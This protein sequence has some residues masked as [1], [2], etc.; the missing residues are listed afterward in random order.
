MR[1]WQGG[2]RRRP[3]PAGL[4]QGKV[5]AGGC[6]RGWHCESWKEPSLRGCSWGGSP[7]SSGARSRKP[8]SRDAPW[9]VY[10]GRRLK[11]SR[12]AGLLSPRQKRHHVY[13]RGR[14]VLGGPCDGWGS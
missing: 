4:A 2:R 1:P 13:T 11:G 8:H 5:R 10:P 7:Q 14:A 6:Q 12:G 3:S 9:V